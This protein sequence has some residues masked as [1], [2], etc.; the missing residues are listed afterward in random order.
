MIVLQFCRADNFEFSRVKKKKETPKKFKKERIV[1]DRIFPP[2]NFFDKK[3]LS[4]S[5]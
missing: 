1:L 4:N 2:E 5:P 3:C